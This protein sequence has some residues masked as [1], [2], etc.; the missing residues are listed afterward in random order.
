M[1]IY[2]SNMK[3]M[4]R[5]NQL[6]KL[7]NVIAIDGPAGAG[8]STVAREVAHRMQYVYL[9]TGAMYRALTVRALQEPVDLTEEAALA[10]L[11]ARTDI[12]LRPGTYEDSRVRVFVDQKEVTDQLRTPEV[13]E[14]V[15]Y[16]AQ[17][18]AVRHHM[19]VQQR[20][21]AS[22]GWVVAEGRDIASHVLPEAGCKIFLTASLEERA[23][24]RWEELRAAGYQVHKETVQENL[25]QRDRIDSE[26]KVAPLVRVPDAYVIDSSCLTIEQVVEMVVEYCKRGGLSAIRPG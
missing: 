6:A 21:L 25:R 11:A 17:S 2:L 26:R 5:D 22:A 24:R 13:N 19:K 16:V 10:Q 4:S 23:R 3:N 9:D 15:S 14:A 8:K 18:P 20:Q 7:R 12:E 1:E